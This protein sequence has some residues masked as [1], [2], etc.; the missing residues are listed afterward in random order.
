MNTT[1]FAGIRVQTSLKSGARGC[2]EIL[3]KTDKI[4]ADM[5]ELRG[6]MGQ[7]AQQMS[8]SEQPQ[9]QSVLSKLWPF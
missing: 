5:Q 6:Q 2:D 9:Q 3:G 7:M 8:Q 4:I 1:T